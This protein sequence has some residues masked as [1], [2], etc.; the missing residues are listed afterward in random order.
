MRSLV[1]WDPF[2]QLESSFPGAGAPSYVPDVELRET[3][4]TYVFK[5][6]VPGV[7][8]SDVEISVMGNRV[9]ISGKREEEETIEDARFFAYERNYG[10]FSRS[11]SLPEGADVDHIQA[12]MKN[13]VLTI[14]VP[15]R[16]EVQ[17]RRIRV[18]PKSGAQMG[19]S[20][21]RET[22]EADKTGSKRTKAA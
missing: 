15:K 17:P 9:T 10:S 4:N 19:Q 5:A 20:K 1:G 13:G 3:K 14:T 21:A 12:E 11:F 18:A 8:E 7:D 2:R 6:D 22:S 16:P